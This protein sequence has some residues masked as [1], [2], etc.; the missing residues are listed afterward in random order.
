M[1]LGECSGATV[2]FHFH[3][4][5]RHHEIFLGEDVMNCDRKN[6]A[7]KFHRVFKKSDDLIAAIVIAG[8][9]AATGDMPGDRRIECLEDR[10]NVALRE[11]LVRLTNN[12]SV[13]G[14][15]APP[16]SSS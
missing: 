4:Y 16:Y 3:S 9:R 2:A 15:I 5:E 8:D 7:A 10:G 12:R 1:D 13:V 11:V 6:T 14:I